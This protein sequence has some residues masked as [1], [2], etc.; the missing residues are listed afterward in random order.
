VVDQVDLAE[1]ALNLK[2][3]MQETLAQ[4]CLAKVLMVGQLVVLH[5]HLLI[6]EE[7]VEE[8]LHQLEL[9]LPVRLVVLAA[10]DT[11]GLIQEIHMVAEVVAAQISL[12]VVVVADLAVVVQAAPQV[13]LGKLELREQVVVVVAVA[14]ELMALVAVVLADQV[15]LS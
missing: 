5:R 8:E 11:L 3:V 10:L 9:T 15:Q 7:L 12:V 4:A 2:Q 14:A 6:L 1:E 13:R